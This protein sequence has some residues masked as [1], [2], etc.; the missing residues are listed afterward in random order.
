MPKTKTREVMTNRISTVFPT[1]KI[2]MPT[3]VPN[4]F[5][6]VKMLPLAERFFSCPAAAKLF[7]SERFIKPILI[8]CHNIMTATTKITLE[9]DITPTSAEIFIAEED[10]QT[11]KSLGSLAFEIFNAQIQNFS[12]GLHQQAS[13]GNVGMDA[14]ARQ[15]EE[16]EFADTHEY[17]ELIE[18]CGNQWSMSPQEQKEHTNDK[19]QPLEVDLFIQE[20]SCHTDLYRQEWVKKYQKIYCEKHPA[21]SRSCEKGKATDLCSL[22]TVKNMPDADRIEF[23]RSRICKL[24]PQAH[25]TV[26]NDPDIR[27]IVQDRCPELLEKSSPQPKQEEL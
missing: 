6:A 10:L 3:S 8:D 12:R 5:A 11:T 15:S 19:N 1:E 27:K 17:F 13:L 9:N 16:Y 22:N 7:N 25:D 23:V 4:V 21:D 18:Q 20:I 14:Y 24:F 2:F 26:K